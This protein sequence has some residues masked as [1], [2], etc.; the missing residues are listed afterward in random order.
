M[1]TKIHQSQRFID[2]LSG[3]SNPEGIVFPHLRY[4][5]PHELHRF[6]A[7]SRMPQRWGRLRGSSCR[8][9]RRGSS[10]RKLKRGSS[11]R[12][13][14]RGQLRGSS[15]RNFRRGSSCKIL[16]DINN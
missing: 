3:G 9:V 7:I 5:L 16:D 14:K 6:F 15:C 12:N 1:A 11:C 2:L 13:L 10:C 8:D 4:E